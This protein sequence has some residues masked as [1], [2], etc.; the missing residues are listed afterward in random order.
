MTKIL[1]LNFDYFANFFNHDF[2]LQNWTGDKFGQNWTGD[3]FL[4]KNW[5]GDKKNNKLDEPLIFFTE[6]VKYLVHGKL[7]VKKCLNRIKRVDLDG[8][9]VSMVPPKKRAWKVPQFSSP[10]VVFSRSPVE[11]SVSA[12]LPNS[13]VIVNE[14]PTGS[15]KIPDLTSV[16]H[17]IINEREQTFPEPIRLQKFTITGDA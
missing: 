5:T 7:R 8:R 16:L 11:D 15:Q 4:G 10:S 1:D 9:P 2:F 13:A 6:V 14:Q 12:R 3:N 17:N